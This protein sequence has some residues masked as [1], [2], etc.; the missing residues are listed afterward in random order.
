M[1]RGASNA[2]TSTSAY[3]GAITAI[4]MPSVPIPWEASSANVLLGTL[5]MALHAHNNWSPTRNLA[6][7]LTTRWTKRL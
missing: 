1:H 5:E 2:W 4:R 7:N 6:Y 3:T